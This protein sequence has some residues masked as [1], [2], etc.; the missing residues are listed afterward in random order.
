MSIL[1]FIFTLFYLNFNLNIF[2]FILIL[3]LFRNLTNFISDY[4]T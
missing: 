3:E 2:L 4:F 1:Y